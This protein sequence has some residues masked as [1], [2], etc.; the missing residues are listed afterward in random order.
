[1]HNIFRLYEYVCRLISILHIVFIVD[2]TYI[3][4]QLDNYIYTA[5]YM[6]CRV[7]YTLQRKMCDCAYVYAY[8]C[9]YYVCESVG[10]CACG[11][12]F[13]VYSCV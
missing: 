9:V 5:V 2:A 4:K 13:F 6:V 11:F 1:M 7:N 8:M 10:V 12:A 3:Y